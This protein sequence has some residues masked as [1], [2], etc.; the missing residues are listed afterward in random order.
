MRYGTI[1]GSAKE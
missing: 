1:K